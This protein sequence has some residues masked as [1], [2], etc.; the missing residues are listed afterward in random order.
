MRSLFV[1]W[2]VAPDLS[3]AA[4]EAAGA[5]QAELRAKHPGLRTGLYQRSD[6]A[7]G[8]EGIVTCMETY[9]IE[10]GVGAA[11]AAAIEA[12]GSGGLQSLGAPRRHVEVFDAVET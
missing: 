7:A 2:K 11:L 6:S 3:V 12:A 5:W 8:A 1:Y 4:L 9:A 10:G